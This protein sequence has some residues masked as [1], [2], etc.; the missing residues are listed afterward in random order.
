MAPNY[1]KYLT[2]NNAYVT[3]ALA[4]ASWVAYSKL[5]KKGKAPRRLKQFYL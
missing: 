4:A 2:K 3:A 5:Q 1:S